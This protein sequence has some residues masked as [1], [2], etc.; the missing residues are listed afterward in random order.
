MSMDYFYLSKKE[1]SE[2]KG[3]KAMSSKELQRKLRDLGKSDRGSR[4]ELVQRYERYAPQEEQEERDASSASALASRDSGSDRR[5]AHASEHPTM[6]MVD[7]ATGNRYM[8]AV[9]HNGLGGEGDESWLV[10][11]I[12]RSLSLGAT[13]EVARTLLSSRAMGSRPSLPCARPWRDATVA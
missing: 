13:R 12:T 11:D 2:K 3:A 8:R 1:T 9:E 7:E 10:K 6:V 4:P 5:G